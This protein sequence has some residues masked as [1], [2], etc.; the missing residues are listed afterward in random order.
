MKNEKANK[1]YVFLKE[2]KAK[3]KFVKKLCIFLMVF[4]TLAMIADIA[5]FFL[6]PAQS[7]I[8]F[9]PGGGSGFS[10]PESGDFQM[11]EGGEMPSGD[12]QVPESGE[13]PS[14]DFQMPESGEMPEGGF[15]ESTD[16][17]MPSFEGRPGG[18]RGGRQ[19]GFLQTVR[20]AW[21]PIAIV[22][23]LGDT[24]CLMVL[25]RI[26]RKEKA[27]AEA[28]DGVPGMPMLDEEE[29]PDE[30]PKRR[31]GP[32]AAILCL[33]VAFAMILGMIP[34]ENTDASSA[35]IHQE[36]ISGTAE[37][38]Q[39]N[40][41]LS[42]AGT[43][44]AD[45]LTAVTVPQQVTVLKYHVRNGETVAA[46]DPLVSVDK[47]SAS[48]AMM[49]LYDVLDDLDDDLEYERQASNSSYIY[50]TAA[51]R[52]KKIYANAGDTVTDVLY[53]HGALML[54]SLDGLMKVCFTSD[55]DLTVGDTVTVKY[56][57]GTEEGRIANVRQG[58]VT[59]TLSDETAW[60]GA[61]VTI[62]DESGNTLGS[63]K[64][65]I[66]SE[67]K[68][69]GYYGTVDSVSVDV[70]DK[71]SVGTTLLTLEDT[72][73]TTDYQILLARRN[74]LEEQMQKLSQLA[75]TGMVYAENDGIVSGVPD[76]AEIEL[77]SSRSS[78]TVKANNLSATSG[79]WQLVLLSNVVENSD[80]SVE[81]G[82]TDNILTDD[83]T[84]SNEEDTLG[85]DV[86][87]E[88]APVSNDGIALTD[89][90]SGNEDSGSEGSGSEGSGS[91]SSGN[92]G[93]GSEGSGSEGSDGEGTGNDGSDDEGNNEPQITTMYYAAYIT[94][95]SNTS[96]SV[97]YSTDTSITATSDPKSYI[98][99][100][101]SSGTFTLDY[102]NLKAGDYLIIEATYTS[103]D[104]TSAKVVK[105]VPTV[106]DTTPVDLNGNYA[107]YLIQSSGGK[108]F[109]GLYPTALTDT[110]ADLTALKEQ[111]T[112]V[113]G[114]VFSGSTDSD[115]PLLDNGTTSNVK[116]A[117][118]KANDLLV[119]TFDRGIITGIVR[120]QR[121]AA[122]QGEGGQMPGG[123]Q[124]GGMPSGGASMGGMPSSGGMAQ[125][126]TYD[127]YIVEET[128][129]LYVSDQKE[130]SVTISVDEL[131]ILSV[132][133]GMG[134][135]VTLDAAKGQSF[136]GNIDR[137]G[138]EG[139]NDGGNTKFSVTVVLP[140]EAAM[141]DGMNASVKIVTAS[142]D[143]AVT[144]PAAALVED[145]GKTYV[146]T[147][148]DEETDA[149]G[150]LTEVDTGASDGESVEILS[151][152][153]VGDTFYYRYADTVTYSFLTT[154]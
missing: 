130:I 35:N 90:D 136:S 2:H 111:M 147:T 47:T 153:N 28:F 132:Q 145:D 129:L 13:M 125:Q 65:E 6:T 14:G 92:E 31:R 50:S 126:E 58:N 51:G 79:G 80:S 128:E 127:Q 137:I 54:L 146:Y 144:I 77:L 115:I 143:A 88:D 7:Q 91:E 151:G 44:E 34:T 8:S 118:L 106:E 12:F 49:D 121:P 84:A 62:L 64:L 11:P 61:E 134:V 10:M 60:Y 70:G 97:N 38:A 76:N 105:H 112:Q 5:N 56:S 26:R 98:G 41:V 24:V 73:Y 152:L 43:L 124:T 114:F 72:G 104:L 133:T 19:G 3:S 63:G 85:G 93:S 20:N 32:W 149:L 154:I 71:V 4:F 57:G 15:G 120:A 122:Q 150:G 1:S 42:G 117:D 141:L 140:R 74:E 81:D 40:T 103:S 53:E 36:V 135:Q 102:A 17:E 18:D 21:L 29:D 75:Q 68:V 108:L 27:V 37:A 82:A 46:G 123:G 113:D 116:L 101:S 83:D 39:I 67:L 131:D 87:S 86:A 52:V 25:L 78:G 96:V 16:G 100:M 109:I 59:V 148:Y 9:G 142:S 110:N 138:H 95:V 30:P 22:C 55:E 99:S 89:E 33:V 48:S 45:S 69:I 66:N 119:V 139:T 107:A 23:I 94:T